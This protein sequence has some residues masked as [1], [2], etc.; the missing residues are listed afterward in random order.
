MQQY[1]QRQPQAQQ[2]QAQE[3]GTQR[4]DE[5]T[6]S[7]SEEESHSEV[8]DDDRP[9]GLQPDRPVTPVS[10]TASSPNT[11]VSLLI[12]LSHSSLCSHVRRELFN[13]SAR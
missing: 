10:D 1:A 9:E 4:D 11:L 12:T 5:T 2:Y 8:F 6:S 13:A 3:E 7:E